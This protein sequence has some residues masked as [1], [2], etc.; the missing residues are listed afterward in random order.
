[1]MARPSTVAG[2][3]CPNMVI[4]ENK[5]PSNLGT[6]ELFFTQILCITLDCC[7]AK[8]HNENICIS[9]LMKLPNPRI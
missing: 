8:P 9:K 2:T 6:L 3:Y 1:M 5:I 4:S 7:V